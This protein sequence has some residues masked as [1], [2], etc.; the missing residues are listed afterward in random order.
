MAL[1]TREPLT[2]EQVEFAPATI[3][4]FADVATVVG[5]SATAKGS[6]WLVRKDLK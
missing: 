1:A 3:D 4:R 6:C 2:P 5:P